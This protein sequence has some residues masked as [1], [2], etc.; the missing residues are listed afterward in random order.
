MI[1]IA[2]YDNRDRI[3][4]EN[5]LRLNASKT[6]KKLD[7]LFIGSSYVYSGIIPGTFDSLGLNTFNLGVATSGPYFNE[8]I[9][10]DYLS[11]QP[12]PGLICIAIAYTTFSEIASDI[13]DQYPI[14]RYLDSPVSNEKVFLNYTN[15]KTYFAML[16]K[17]FKKGSQNFLTGQGGIDT[18]QLNLIKASKG[19]N[20]SL[21]YCTRLKLEEEEEIFNPYLKSTF[22]KKKEKKLI[23]LIEKYSVAGINIVVVAPPTFKLKNFFSDKYKEEYQGFISRL[24]TKNIT[25]LTDID[26]KYDPTCFRNTDHLN[27]KGAKIFSEFLKSKLTTL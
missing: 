12:A 26:E 11:S 5:I 14:H 8:L 18:V 9:I 24:K 3:T 10:N 6:N 20:K 23:E 25:F 7:I 13:W 17:S 19:Y 22:N 15:A 21:D 16:R 1:V 27:F 2:K 4:D